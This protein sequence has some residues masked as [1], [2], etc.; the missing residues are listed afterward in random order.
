MSTTLN[1]APPA[2]DPW[3]RRDHEKFK[4]P[5][6][7]QR[8]RTI[9]SALGE[10]IILHKRRRSLEILLW[11]FFCFA[12]R[13]SVHLSVR[14]SPQTAPS[15]MKL[16]SWNVAFRHIIP[17]QKKVFEGIYEIWSSSWD[18]NV[19]LSC[20]TSARSERLLVCHP[21][22]FTSKS[23]LIDEIRELK[24]CIQT[25]HINSKKV[26]KGIFWTFHLWLNFQI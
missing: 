15:V 21:L 4:P 14:T 23:F 25:P 8:P 11:K 1:I 19:F 18:V 10:T 16:E 5:S 2:Y 26:T 13:P 6:H 24:Y 9:I 3:A 12:C 17:L 7:S 20:Q 22:S